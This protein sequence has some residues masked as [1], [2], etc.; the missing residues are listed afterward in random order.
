ME[1][2][3]KDTTNKAK[4]TN[5]KTNALHGFIY[6]A[7]TTPFLWPQERDTSYAVSNLEHVCAPVIHP[8][9]GK[10]IY[11]YKV[12]VED[13]MLKETWTTAFGK[14]FGSLA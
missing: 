7:A 5:F 13:A 2:K 14:E 3:S 12:L 4:P 8:K 10:L 11:K 1:Y 9:T 6:H